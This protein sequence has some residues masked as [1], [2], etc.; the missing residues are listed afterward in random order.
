MLPEKDKT[1]LVAM[2][3]GVDSSAAAALLADQGYNVIGATMKLW[4]YEEVG[5]NINHESGCCSISNINDA[6]IVCDRLGIP[7]YVVNFSERFSQT[8]VSDFVSEYMSGRTPNPCVLCNTK[9]KWEYLLT[10][11]EEFGADYV[12]TGHYARSTFDKATGRYRL[13]KGNDTAKDQS[14]A[15]WG[16]KQK[17]L[18]H[19]LFPLSAYTKPETRKVAER[20][21]LRIAK[22]SESQEICFVP[23]DDYH[24]FLQRNSREKLKN[25][26]K[27]ELVNL[28]GEVV[29]E[30]YGY[31]FYTI[32]QRR[33]VGK[34]MVTG[35]GDKLYVVDIQPDTNKVVIG[36]EEALLK[37]GLKARKLNLIASDKLIDAKQ[38][39]VKIRY[40]DSG[41]PANVQQTSEDEIQV[42]FESPRKSVT[43]GQSVV[44]YDGSEV[45]GG[46]I[47]EEALN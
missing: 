35:F 25:I 8:V 7:H 21:G 37:R 47:I 24:G 11:A 17:A 18:A 41:Q 14:Y 28:E 46:A 36:P 23:D 4:D 20:F 45:V 22:K 6:R 9:I 38:Y 42:L 19:T 13:F 30:H 2:S 32:G 40:N 12:A 5:G 34:G 26:R 15:L 16:V 44:F 39:L 33:G 1:V 10:R 31:P 29:G 3:G 43:P 27:G